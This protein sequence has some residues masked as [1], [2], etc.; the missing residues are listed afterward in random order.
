[1]KGRLTARNTEPP[2]N[3]C[4][5]Y[6]CFWAFYNTASPTFLDEWSNLEALWNQPDPL[7]IHV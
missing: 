7:G 2:T 1:M 5:I 4:Q 3:R 6:P